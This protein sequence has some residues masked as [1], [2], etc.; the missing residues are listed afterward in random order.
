MAVAAALAACAAAFPVRAESPGDPAAKLAALKQEFETA[1]EEWMKALR[2]AKTEEEGQ[3]IWEAQPGKEFLPRFEA[4]AVEAKGTA[5]ACAAWC[6]VFDVAARTQAKPQARRAVDTI[7]AEHLTSPELV[8]FV[9]SLGEMSWILGA[10]ET[11]AAL[12]KLVEGSPHRT[13]QAPALFGYGTAMLDSTDPA[14]EARARASLERVQKDFAD[15]KSKRGP[16]YAD[17]AKGFLFELDHLQIGML[18]PDFEALDENG[19]KFKVSDYR[20]KVVVLD[21][22]GYW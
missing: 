12:W 20:G 22:W 5:V 4:V 2:A 17:R 9:Q 6:E 21:F 11:G 13:V 10:A 16:S 19:Q 14:L 15:V 18:A 1:Q 3:K 7:L 8:P